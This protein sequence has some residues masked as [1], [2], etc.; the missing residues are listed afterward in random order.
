MKKINGFI[1]L[2]CTAFISGCAGNTAA[3]SE[4]AA[5]AAVSESKNN[6]AAADEMITPENVV[7]EGMVPVYA[8]S[9]N[10]GDYSVTVDSS[11]AMFN[12]TECVLHVKNGSMTAD[13]TM[14]GKGYLYIFMGTGEEASA[15]GESGYIHFSENA[16]G[17][18]CYT[19]PVEALDAGINCAAF[20]KNKEKWYDRVLLFRADSLPESAFS[21]GYFSTASS[22]SL[23]DGEYTVEVS[24]E[25]GSGRAGVSSPT[26]LVIENGNAFAEIEFS[27]S[28]YDYMIVGE[29]KF[30]PINTEGNSKFYIPVSRFD[31]RMPVSADTTAMS[32]AH[33]ISYTL[34]FDSASI[35]EKS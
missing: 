16:D 29:E 17:S 6:V 13:M 9:L 20:S 19:V 30:E 4:T 12:I 27:S 7:E 3:L 11:S 22:L 5:S 10:D 24:L 21:D 14:G 32:M 31:S 18:H 25:G 33:E 1:I 15:A 23:A 26:R 8:S 2:V 28:N 34:C 35:A